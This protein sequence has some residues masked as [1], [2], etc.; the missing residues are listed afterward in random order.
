TTLGRLVGVDVPQG[1]GVLWVFSLPDEK[2]RTVPRPARRD[3]PTRAAA[4]GVYTAAQAAQGEQIFRQECSTC[5]SA[6]NYTGANFVAKWS[7][8][9]LGDVYQ[10]ISLAMPPANPG[11]L[12]P[13]SYASILAYFLAGSGYPTG[14]A[15]LP[16]DPRRLGAIRTGAAAGEPR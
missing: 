3:E 13:V 2:P 16:G 15:E 10:D 6:E 11:G 7:G 8:V 4:D 1:S 5:H 14:D 9:T 12:T